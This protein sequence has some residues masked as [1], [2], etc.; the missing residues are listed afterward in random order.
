MA[1]RS[2]R[3]KRVPFEHGAFRPHLKVFELLIL[4]GGLGL[5]DKKRLV[6][7]ATTTRFRPS[8]LARYRAL[9]TDVNR[10]VL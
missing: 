3:P 8:F 10:D 4:G 7:Y 2:S 6:P 1:A 5:A 9:S